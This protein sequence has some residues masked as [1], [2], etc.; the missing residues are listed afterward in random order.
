M[1]R[2]LYHYR[3]PLY[4]NLTHSGPKHYCWSLLTYFP[5]FKELRDLWGHL[6]ACVPAYTSTKFFC[7]T[8]S[9]G[10]TWFIPPSTFCCYYA[11]LFHLPHFFYPCSFLPPFWHILFFLFLF[12]LLHFSF[13]Y[14]H[15]LFHLFIFSSSSS[16]FFPCMLLSLLCSDLKSVFRIYKHRHNSITV[17]GSVSVTSM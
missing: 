10:S 12:Y 5:S 3:C 1:N 8:V 13:L 15:L 9:K 6:T 7:W 4:F 16:S 2:T 14:S 17:V 11:L